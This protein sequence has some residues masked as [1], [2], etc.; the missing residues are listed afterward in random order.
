MLLS[1]IIV[2]FHLFYDGAVDIQIWALLT[3]TQCKVSDT[4]VTVKACRPLVWL[5]KLVNLSY[6]YTYLLSLYTKY[7]VYILISI[8][9]IYDEQVYR[10]ITFQTHCGHVRCFWCQVFV[11]FYFVALVRVNRILDYRSSKVFQYVTC[12][13]ELNRHPTSF[14]L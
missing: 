6:M 10:S 4:Q 14:S 3:R 7:T 1:D 13:S 11:P 8:Y 9:T 5:C 2:D 12:L